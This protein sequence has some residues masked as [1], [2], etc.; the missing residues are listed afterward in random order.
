MN[1]YIEKTNPQKYSEW[2][3]NEFVY[4]REK[5]SF[6]DSINKLL[7]DTD[8]GDTMILILPMELGD[9]SFKTGEFP[10]VQSYYKY[11][12]S[13]YYPLSKERFNFVNFSQFS[14]IK[15]PEKKAEFFASTTQKSYEGTR[16]A[17]AILKII[18][19]E[20]KSELKTGGMNLGSSEYRMTE[21]NF[22]ILE[23]HCVDSPSLYY[24]YIGGSSIKSF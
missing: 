11:S 17:Y 23:L 1:S 15:V 24:N 3:D 12:E 21:Y 20:V 2:N 5:E 4:H 18:P 7:Q 16:S 22:K 14:S 13:I 9:Y 19:I 10:V 8:L 6:L